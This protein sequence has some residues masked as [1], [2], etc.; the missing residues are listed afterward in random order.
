MTVLESESGSLDVKA[1]D[2]L[3]YMEI[4]GNFGFC[5]GLKCLVVAFWKYVLKDSAAVS[6]L[7]REQW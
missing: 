6:G 3:D 1:Q 2:E 4:F 5:Q 7:N